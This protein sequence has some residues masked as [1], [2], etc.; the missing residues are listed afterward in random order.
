[1]EVDG[2]LEALY[3]IRFANGEPVCFSEL[4]AVARNQK[5]A[6]VQGIR[7]LR[8]ALAEH[9]GVVAYATVGEPT[10]DAFIRHVGFAHVG[11]SFWGEEVYQYE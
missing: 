8:K 11:T 7:L 3:G 1:M 4:S 5:R 9:H 6:I 2:T 10:A